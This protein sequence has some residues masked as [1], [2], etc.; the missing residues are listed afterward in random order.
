M[1][2]NASRR[3]GE[4]KDDQWELKKRFMNMRQSYHESWKNRQKST[5]DEQK[6]NINPMYM[7]MNGDTKKLTQN[8]LIEGTHESANI[9]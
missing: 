7:R 5:F 8:G 2:D 6:G 3:N 9:A 1:N 4:N